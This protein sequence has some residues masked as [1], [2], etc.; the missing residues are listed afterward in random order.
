MGNKLPSIV[1][2]IFSI[3]A[4]SCASTGNPPGA[5]ALPGGPAREKGLEAGIDRK[6]LAMIVLDD[7]SPIWIEDIDGLVQ[8]EAIAPG[9]KGR[10]LIKPGRRRIGYLFDRIIEGSGVEIRVYAPTT[11]DFAPGTTYAPRAV[12]GRFADQVDIIQD[13]VTAGE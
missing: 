1:L 11:F 9:L 5:R 12:A 6:E 13:T 7:A 2:L 4:L 10:I 3:L 8:H